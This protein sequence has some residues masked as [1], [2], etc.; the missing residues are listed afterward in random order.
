MQKIITVESCDK[1]KFEDEVNELLSQGYKMCTCSCGFIDNERYDFCSSY[2]AVLIVDNDKM[3]EHFEIMSR[4]ADTE[5]KLNKAVNFLQYVNSEA[6]KAMWGQSSWNDIFTEVNTL[7]KDLTMVRAD[8]KSKQRL[9]MGTQLV[10]DYTAQDFNRKLNESIEII[11]K[12]GYTNID[13]KYS[14]QANPNKSSNLI[15]SALI[16]YKKPV[17]DK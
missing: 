1:K 16:A 2:Q 5:L 6:Y 11:T 14:T 7:L 13:V 8:D 15:Y 3:N 10:W 17:G 4:L 9:N 12:C